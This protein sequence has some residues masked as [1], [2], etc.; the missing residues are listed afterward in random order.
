MDIRGVISESNTKM[1][2]GVISDTH[3]NVKR[4]SA[5]IEET[6][7][8]DLFLHLGDHAGDLFALS[9]RFNLI[10]IGILGNEDKKAP[11]GSSSKIPAG[12][13]TVDV[14]DIVTGADDGPGR[15]AGI[16][17]FSNEV[18]LAVRGIK[19]YVVH[20]HTF[21]LNPYYG[22]EKWKKSLKGLA[23]RAKEGG[24]R[25]VLFGHTHRPFLEVVDDL[26]FM[27]PG[28]VYPG[29]EWGHI[30][31]IHIS[32]SGVDAEIVRFNERQGLESL[33]EIVFRL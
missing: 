7:P 26:L 12:A 15:P 14:V 1:K 25:V 16:V 10:S 19:I 22:E 2:I 6:L 30:G 24:A 29:A 28:D 5:I 23:A 11:T 18:F 31:T 32:D 20:G 21:D 33:S 8:F 9:E 4:A 17:S 3:G 13:E 27:N